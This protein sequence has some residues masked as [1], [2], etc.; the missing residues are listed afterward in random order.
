MAQH[1]VDLPSNHL[2]SYD[3]YGFAVYKQ[4]SLLAEEDNR[5]H[6]YK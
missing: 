5:S 3:H 6:D 2:S 1:E 4:G